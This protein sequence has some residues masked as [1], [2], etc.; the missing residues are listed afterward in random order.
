MSYTFVHKGTGFSPD[1]SSPPVKITQEESDRSNREMSAQEVEDFKTNAPSPYFAYS[2][3]TSKDARPLS[4]LMR[5][6]KIVT[7]MGDELTKVIEAFDP[8]R[9]N[10]GGIRQNFR[11]RSI[12]GKTTY[13]G[14]AYLS[15]GDYVRMRKVKS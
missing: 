1:G 13:S 14:T 2:K 4:R 12:D 6:D 11:A 15:A 7:W 3:W 8:F 5:E 10:F 9:D